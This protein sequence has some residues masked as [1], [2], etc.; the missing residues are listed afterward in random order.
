[1]KRLFF[2]LWPEQTTRQSCIT[3]ISQLPNAGRPVSARN[4]HI[5]LLFLGSVDSSQQA[6]ISQEAGKLPISPITITFDRLSF[7]KKPGVLCLTAGQTDRN[8]TQLNNALTSIAKQ[9]GILVDERPFTPHV[10]LMKKARTEADIAISPI[11]WRAHG[12]C[13]AESIS[14]AAGVEYR[15]IERWPKTDPLNPHLEN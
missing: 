4:L 10:T 14:T 1:M 9:H 5:T 13:L 12:F 15:I 11:L 6:L 8:I 2:A 7:W 3:L